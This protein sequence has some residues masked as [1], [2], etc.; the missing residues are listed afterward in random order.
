[1]ATEHE[2]K[3]VPS[4][5]PRISKYLCTRCGARMLCLHDFGPGPPL[6]NCER[7]SEALCDCDVP[8]RAILDPRICQACGMYLEDE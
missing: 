7:L 1:M 8:L 5:Y 3:E 2:W 4:G 6:D